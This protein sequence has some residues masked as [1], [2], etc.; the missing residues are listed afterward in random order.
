[1]ELSII[2][3]RGRHEDK[4]GGT[5]LMRCPRAGRQSS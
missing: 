1:V 3:H 2:T 4:P 5:R